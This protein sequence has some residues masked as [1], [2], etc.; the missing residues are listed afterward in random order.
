M[1]E[2]GNI[3]SIIGFRERAYLVLPFYVSDLSLSLLFPFL[4]SFK[5]MV[6]PIL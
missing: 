5:V 3:N 4:F 2:E 1:L 6:M